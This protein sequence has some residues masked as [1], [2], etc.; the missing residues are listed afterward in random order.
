MIFSVVHHNL[1]YKFAKPNDLELTRTR[2][3]EATNHATKLLPNAHAPPIRKREAR[4]G[5]SEVLG[6]VIMVQTNEILVPSA[7]GIFR[8]IQEYVFSHRS[9][10]TPLTKSHKGNANSI[11]ERKPI[12]VNISSYLGKRIFPKLCIR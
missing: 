1:F 6:L 3:Y 11:I 8:Q 12:W 9:T 5:C 10:F 2:G 7:W 4:V